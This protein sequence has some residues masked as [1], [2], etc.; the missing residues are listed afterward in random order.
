MGGREKKTPN[1]YTIHFMR[2]KIGFI[3]GKDHMK[4]E[5]SAGNL[6]ARQMENIAPQCRWNQTRDVSNI[7]SRRSGASSLER[8]SYLQHQCVGRQWKS[9]RQSETVN[10]EEGGEGAGG[11]SGG[12]MKEVAAERWRSIAGVIWPDADA[13]GGRRYTPSALLAFIRQLTDGA[14]DTC[15]HTPVCTHTEAPRHRRL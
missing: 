13:R 12:G 11:F 6:R 14:I 4:G 9:E 10:K 15:T 7:S 1:S 5:K 2:I 8:F 3:C